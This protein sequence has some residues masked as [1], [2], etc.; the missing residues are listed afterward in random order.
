MLQDYLPVLMQILIAS[1]FAASTL[2][3][4]VLVGKSGKSNA[5]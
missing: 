4:S 3:V 5:M 2:L 1:G